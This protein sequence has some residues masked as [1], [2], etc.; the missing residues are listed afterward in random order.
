MGKIYTSV[1]QLIGGT[2]LLELTHLERELGL[3]TRILGKLESFNPGGSAKDRIAKSM[4]DDGEARGILKSGSV[5]IEPT[6]GN[7]GIGLALVAAARGYRAIIVMPDTMSQERRQLLLAY[8]AEVVLTEGRLGMAGAI[9]FALI[10]WAT[11]IT[12]TAAAS[13]DLRAQTDLLVERL[14]VTALE[15]CGPILDEF[16]RAS[17]SSVMLVDANGHIVQDTNSQLSIQSVYEDESTIV[18]VT[19]DSMFT[20]SEIQSLW[21]G[22][23]PAAIIQEDGREYALSIASDTQVTEVTFAGGQTCE[24]YVSPGVRSENLAVAALARMAPWVLLVLL[25]FS[26]LCAVVYSRYITR[27]IVRLSGIA[28]KMAELDFGWICGETRRDEIGALGRSLD[29][30]SQRLSAALTDLRAAN[31]ALLGEMERERELERQRSAFFAAASHELKT[32]VTILKGQLTGM[33]DEVGVYRDRDRYLARSLQVTSRMEALVGEILTISR[34]ESGTGLRKEEVDLSRLVEE[35]LEQDRELLDQREMDL[36]LSLAPGLVLR[37]D[38]SLL[39]RAVDNLLSNAA[40]YSPAGARIRVRT[41]RLDGRPTLV[42]ENTGVQIG[43]EALPRLFEPFYREE[44]SRN[45][46]TGGSGLGLYLVKMI[47]D[48]HGA[49]CEIE[50]I[51]DGVRVRVIFPPETAS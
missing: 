19:S 17:K 43:A 32:P 7:T 51:T 37:G 29:R 8:G 40:L 10:A 4:L 47:L 36:S 9:T 33:L 39:G 1:E 44:Q 20:A 31:D 24:L 41:L 35:Q 27:P 34:M 5:I 45:R 48:R 18:T 38:P 14:S 22:D 46:R 21:N 42:V 16:I 6:S 3:S 30:M 23:P 15:D 13:D 28:G 2:P 49:R 25:A 12:Y 26:A 11:P 50:N